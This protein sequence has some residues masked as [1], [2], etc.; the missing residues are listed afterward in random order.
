MLLLEVDVSKGNLGERNSTCNAETNSKKCGIAAEANYEIP[1]GTKT[2]QFEGCETSR[3]GTRSFPK[4]T[5]ASQTHASMT[6]QHDIL[7]QRTDGA[8]LSLKKRTHRATSKIF[9]VAQ[10]PSL[11]PLLSYTSSI[12]NF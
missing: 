3:L 10:R 7:A 6:L 11:L 1:L 2:H 4:P 5:R 9:I 8:L 12:L